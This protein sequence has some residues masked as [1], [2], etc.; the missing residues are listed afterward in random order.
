MRV[1]LINPPAAA[2][3]DMVR[4]GR[5][6]QRAGAWTAVWPPI[7]LATMAAVLRDHG[8]ECRLSD[9]IIEHADLAELKRGVSGWKPDVAIINTATPSIEHDLAVADEI[10][11]VAP[12][13]VTAAIG[14]HVTALPE[15]SLAMSDGLD[16]VIMGEPELTGLDLARAVSG[17]RPLSGIAGLALRRGRGEG[18]ELADLDS[19]PF[20]AWDLARRE[21]YTLPFSGRPFLMVGTSRGCPYHCRFCADPTYYGHKLRTRS[22]GGIVAEIKRDRDEFGVRD[23]LFWSESFTLKREWTRQVLEEL[24][25][26]D[27]GVR[28][29]VNSR[30]DHVDPELLK[31]LRRAGCWMIGYGVE[32]GS[33]RVLDL[34]GKKITVEDNVNA[35]RWAREAG[36]QVTAHM[37]IGYPGERAEDIEQTVRFACSQPIDFAQFYCAAPFPGSELFKE[38]GEKGW[39]EGSGWESF[40]QNLCA[41]HAPGLSPQE[42]MEWRRRAYLRFYGRPSRMIKALVRD[43]GLRGGPR[44]ARMLLEFRGWI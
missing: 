16:A 6:M 38:A 17:G 25:R 3:V 10:K 24:I 7:S 15:Q 41:L 37:V 31:L 8:F 11:S 35:V 28:F 34:M 20:P 30:T 42:I 23:F 9:C 43:A 18:R 39:I 32:S 29:V 4:E 26:A 5:C 1:H 21:L 27:L 19:L 14:I 36:L 40:E 12:G 44:L 13:C 2:G 33:Q 22:P